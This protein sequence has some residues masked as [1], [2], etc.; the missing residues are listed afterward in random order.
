VSALMASSNWV[1]TAGPRSG[2][3]HGN[4]FDHIPD[5]PVDCQHKKDHNITD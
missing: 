3:R 4:E 1:S 5:N 2:P